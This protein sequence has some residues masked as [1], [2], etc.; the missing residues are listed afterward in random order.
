MG[1]CLLSCVHSKALSPSHLIIAQE[2]CSGEIRKYRKTQRREKQ[3][4]GSRPPKPAG[5]GLQLLGA[6]GCPSA[7][8]YALRA[9]VTQT[10][11]HP[12]RRRPSSDV[13]TSVIV[14]CFTSI[15]CASDVVFSGCVTF[16]WVD[17]SSFSPQ[18]PSR[19]RDCSVVG[20]VFV[21]SDINTGRQVPFSEAPRCQVLQPL[22]QPHRT[23]RWLHG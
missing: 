12:T 8:L 18:V 21:F 15:K 17:T 3:H 4:P 7:P 20:F 23:V 22:R 10:R 11:W 2:I 5:V 6:L 9:R 13:H 14:H 1:V 16:H 19:G